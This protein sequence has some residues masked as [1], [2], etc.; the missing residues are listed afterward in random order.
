MISLQKI[1]TTDAA[2][3]LMDSVSGGGAV[4]SKKT[5]LYGKVTFLLCL[6]QKH[7]A[8]RRYTLKHFETDG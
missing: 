8:G 2:L 7:R 3:S 5:P 1:Q 4:L 6:I